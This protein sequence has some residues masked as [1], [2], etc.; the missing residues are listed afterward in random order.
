MWTNTGLYWWVVRLRLSNAVMCSRIAL[1]CDLIEQASVDRTLC[2]ARRAW[3]WIITKSIL[4][5]YRAHNISQALCTP[6]R[7]AIAIFES[8]GYN[9]YEHGETLRLK[10]GGDVSDKDWPRF[11]PWINVGSIEPSISLSTP[12]RAGSFS[13]SSGN[14]TI[15]NL[16]DR[17]RTLWKLIFWPTEF[18]TWAQ[19]SAPPSTSNRDRT[20]T[21]LALSKAFL[22]LR[23]CELGLVYFLVGTGPNLNFMVPASTS[24]F[25][26]G[27]YASRSLLTE[28]FSII[29]HPHRWRW[30]ARRTT[31]GA[32]IY[33][34]SRGNCNVPL[35]NGLM[36][37]SDRSVLFPERTE[38]T[39]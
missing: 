35:K 38:V 28:Y 6:R 15:P 25:G 12:E 1:I 13:E 18:H 10:G 9:L 3:M 7:A 24:G 2:G 33:R 19:M 17:T 5:P 11:W 34:Q 29:I 30:P 36:V 23:A 16:V 26:R 39:I 22:I 8:S 14:S 27:G 4:F 31:R 20:V 32:R 37:E 21:S